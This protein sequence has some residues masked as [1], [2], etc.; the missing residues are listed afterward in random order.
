MDIAFG[1]RRRVFM[2]EQG[3]PEEIEMDDMDASATHIICKAG[4]EAVATGRLNF[5]GREAKMGRVAVLKEWRKKGVGSKVVEFLL[6]EAI[7]HGTEVV[8]ANVQTHSKDFYLKHGF[9]VTGDIFL[10][11][12]IEHVRMEKSL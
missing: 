2:E 6:E 1:I 9:K 11:A 3:V 10:E 12:D 8:Y 5:F 7:K 4:G